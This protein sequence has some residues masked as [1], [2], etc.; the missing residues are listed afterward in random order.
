MISVIRAVKLSVTLFDTAEVYDPFTNE[1]PVDKAL[2]PFRS[3]TKFGESVIKG[4]MFGAQ[5]NM[6]H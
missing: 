6:I 4:N 5:K 1:E 3:A 2:S